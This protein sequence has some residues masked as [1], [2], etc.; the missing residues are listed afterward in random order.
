MQQDLV[1]QITAVVE[2]IVV[3]D[4]CELVH[5]ELLGQ[6]RNQVLRLYIDK[7]GGV[8]I[9]DCADASNQISVLLDVENLIPTRYL[10]EVCSPGL[11][12][13][14]YKPADY[15][16]F[17]GQ[18]AKVQTIEQLEGRRNF[19]GRLLGIEGDIVTIQEQE[20]GHDVAILYQLIRKAHLV[21][22]WGKGKS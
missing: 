3:G 11:E 10:L 14:L 5:V 21:F 8:T 16:R 13:G 18:E 1:E 7:P 15:Q 20:L 9:D 2:P 6:P 12:R 22:Q 19:H 4:G 17:A